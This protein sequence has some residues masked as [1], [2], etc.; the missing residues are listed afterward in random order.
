[1]AALQGVGVQAV[2][3]EYLIMY[4]DIIFSDKMPTFSSANHNG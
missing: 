1:M 2:V 3:T 4:C